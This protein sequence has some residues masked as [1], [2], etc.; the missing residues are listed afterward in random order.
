[1][2]VIGIPWRD[3]R[4][5]RSPGLEPPDR[6]PTP[7]DV[8]LV[9]IGSIM[10]DRDEF[11]GLWR[12]LTDVEREVLFPWAVDGYPLPG[13]AERLGRPKGTVLSIV[14]GTRQRPRDTGA[15]DR[16]RG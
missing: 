7:F 15:G 11:E 10:I 4:R 6:A 8:G 16:A 3:E 9:S 5:R 2:K 12:A 1:M 13:V 14:H